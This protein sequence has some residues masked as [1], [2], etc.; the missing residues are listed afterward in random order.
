M[1]I[2]NLSYSSKN[3]N[4]TN[5][6]SLKKIKTKGFFDKNWNNHKEIIDEFK[7]SEPIKAFFKK[8]DGYAEFKESSA[9]SP[10]YNSC[11]LSLKFK[12]PDR[13]PKNI[14]ERIL[15]KFMG[16]S[17]EI[18]I[19]GRRWDNV[20][21]GIDKMLLNKIKT[22]KTEELEDAVKHTTE[23]RTA[24]IFVGEDILKKS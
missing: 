2:N 1:E 17:C 6:G 12:N 18:N 11:N 23:H 19:D 3:Y 16:Y 22:L 20:S 15:S 4:N 9:L 7:K 5:F 21:V 10:L 8:Y 24:Y 14:F 13:K